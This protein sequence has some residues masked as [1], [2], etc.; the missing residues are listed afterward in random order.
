MFGFY[1]VSEKMAGRGRCCWAVTQFTHGGK[2]AT[3]TL[4]PLFLGGGWLL[5][6][7]NLERGRQAAGHGT[8]GPATAT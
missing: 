3:L 6:R 8:T 4:L 2:L 7:V 1:S 5:S